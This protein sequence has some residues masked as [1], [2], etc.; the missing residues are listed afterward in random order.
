MTKEEYDMLEATLLSASDFDRYE[1]S[2]MEKFFPN[3]KSSGQFLVDAINQCGYRV[4]MFNSVKKD[5]R[6]HDISIAIA[7]AS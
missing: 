4:V 3:K 5:D 6:T 1:V 7:K 2:L